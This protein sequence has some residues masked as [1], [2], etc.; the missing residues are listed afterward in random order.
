MVGGTL[1]DIRAEI[2]S[3]ACSDGDYAVVC[4]RTGSPPGAAAGQRFPGRRAAGE[5]V[6]LTRDYRAALRRY[7][8]NSPYDDPLVYEVAEGPPRAAEESADEYARYSAFC[9]DTAGALFEALSELGYREAETA[10]METYLTLA[11]VVDDR[12]DFCLTLVWSL[13]SELDV[14]LSADEQRA[15]VET[16]A[17]LFC[18]TP[19]PNPVDAALRHLEAVGFVEGYS[20][21]PIPDA[22]AAGTAGSDARTDARTDGDDSSRTWELTFGDYAL[23][24]RTGRVPTLPLAVALVRRTPERTVRF[25]DGEALSDGRWRLRLRMSPKNGA[26]HAP[27]SAGL[28]SVEAIENRWLNDPSASLGR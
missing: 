24:E 25:L 11:E 10:E 28:V 5:A 14:R 17:G 21:R 26:G 27:G 9:H 22:E 12:D 3:L 15:V 20:V 7:D 8:P 18:P 16:A 19:T 4:G 13:M 6:E 1:R 2:R 23:A